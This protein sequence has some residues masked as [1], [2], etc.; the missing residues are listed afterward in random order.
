M[1][2]PR[3]KNII[4]AL[5]EELDFYKNQNLNFHIES[6]PLKRIRLKATVSQREF[7]NMPKDFISELLLM[8]LSHA[9]EDSIKKLPIKVN[10][11]NDFGIYQVTLD[12]WI[13]TEV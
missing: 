4:K 7:M 8:H 10:F 5:K 11:N 1:N 9:F 6:T 2:K 3:K 12:L 13:N